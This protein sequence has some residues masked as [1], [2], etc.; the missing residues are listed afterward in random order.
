ML[1]V[2]NVTPTLVKKYNSTGTEQA[3]PYMPFFLERYA[4]AYNDEPQA[5]AQSAAKGRTVAVAGV[6]AASAG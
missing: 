5:F 2:G 3:E 1:S 6:A 4:Q